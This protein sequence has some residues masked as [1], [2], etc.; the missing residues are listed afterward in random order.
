MAD[1]EMRRAALLGTGVI[2]AGWAARL[3]HLGVAITAYGPDPAA[4]TR[5]R[6][7]LDGALAALTRLTDGPPST[8]GH[9]DFT[10]DLTAAVADADLIQENVPERL[11]LKKDLLIAA[12]AAA[13][14][15]ALIASS[16]SGYRPR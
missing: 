6:Q 12:G 16:T 3:I 8:A 9:L 14:P 5:L 15:S 1:M 4:E 2:G 10:T 11:E 13:K 7:G